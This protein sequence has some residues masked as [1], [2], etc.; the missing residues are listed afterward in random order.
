MIQNNGDIGELSGEDIQ[1]FSAGEAPL[2]SKK[3]GNYSPL[4]EMVTCDERFNLNNKDTMKKIPVKSNDDEP[5]LKVKLELGDDKKN[6]W[7]YYWAANSSVDVLKINSVDIAYGKYENHA[8]DKTDK[9][10]NII[11]KLNCPQPYREDIDGKERTYCRHIHYIVENKDDNIWSDM[12]TKRIICYVSKDFLNNALQK[13][14]MMIIN[15]LD[16]KHFKNYKIPD[17][18]NLPYSGFPKKISKKHEHVKEFVLSHISNYQSI[19]QEYDESAI[20]IED[21][22]II[23]YCAKSTCDASKKLIDEL[24]KAGF[25]N[26]LEWN[27]GYEG[28]KK[29]ETLFEDAIENEDEDED[30]DTST[31]EDIV[32]ELDGIEYL[33]NSGNIYTYD[34]GKK[35]MGKADINKKKIITKIKWE[36][37]DKKI[38]HEENVELNKVSSDMSDATNLSLLSSI[39]DKEEDEDE[40]EEVEDEEVE[41]EE[42]KKIKIKPAE[43]KEEGVQGDKDED[44]DEDEDEEDEDEE[45]EDEDKDEEDEDEA[46]DEVDLLYSLNDKK[47]EEYLNSKDKKKDD[48]I[49]MIVK[50]QKRTKGSYTL[51]KERRNAG[52]DKE[53]LIK[54][55]TDCGGRIKKG[56]F[57]EGEKNLQLKKLS[58]DELKKIAKN[59]EN[60]DSD[61]YEFNEIKVDKNGK[62]T[63][64][65][66]QGELKDIIKSC[67]GSKMK[68]GGNVKIK[69]G[70]GYSF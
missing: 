8:L 37:E 5:C 35:L 7:V 57:K 58:V 52:D 49:K 48:L 67:R 29:N 56:K 14:N 47:L 60:R 70:W 34:E 20:N 6:S 9:E 13:R 10:G 21:I 2:W 54:L 41:D 36:S 12:V 66:K 50:M 68:G 39:K 65:K 32:V 24:Y 44:K 3:L 23:T 25:N 22:P 61:R 28:Y 43:E 59:I 40:D 69:R 51:D 4:P 64:R 55:I 63:T 62:Y 31:E 42:T 19:K 45:D 18:V 17:T 30:I 1:Q 11:I 38:E 53:K 46:E 33:Y 27:E 16:K 15:A 26:V